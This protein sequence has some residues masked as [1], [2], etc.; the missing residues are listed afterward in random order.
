MKSDIAR[1]LKPLAG[2]LLETVADHPRETGGDLGLASDS[3]R[4][5]SFRIALSV[6]TVE[7]RR[8][9]CCPVAIS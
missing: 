5:S 3:S 2:I 7:P 8:K 6:S 4:G 1:R 9:A